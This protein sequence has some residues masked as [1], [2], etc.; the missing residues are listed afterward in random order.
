MCY[1]RKI[2]VEGDQ[3]SIFGATRVENVLVR[4]SLQLLVPDCLY[5]MPTGPEYLLRPRAKVFVER[6]PQRDASVG[7]S[8]YLCRDISAP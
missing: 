1:V 2:Q 4:G 6:E 5:V 7:R 8:T 3:T